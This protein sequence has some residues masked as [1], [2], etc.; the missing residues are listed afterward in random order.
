MKLIMYDIQK[1]YNNK[2]YNFIQTENYV[3]RYIFIKRNTIL[4][5]ECCSAIKKM[6]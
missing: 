1:N 2:K 6:N 4:N 3:K 5:N